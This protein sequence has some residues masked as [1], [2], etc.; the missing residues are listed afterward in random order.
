MQ[1]LVLAAVVALQL[2][3]MVWLWRQIRFYRM[4]AT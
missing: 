1:G 2:S 3:A 4:V